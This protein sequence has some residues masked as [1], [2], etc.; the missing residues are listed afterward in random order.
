MSATVLAEY[1]SR[2][3]CAQEHNSSLNSTYQLS[4]EFPNLI[5]L[6][7]AGQPGLNH[8]S[9]P[10]LAEL[11]RAYLE[12]FGILTTLTIPLRVRGETIAYA[13]LRES[14]HQRDFTPE[15]IAL[16]QGI[17]QQA[18]VAIKHTQLYDETRRQAADL[19]ALYTVT[20]MASQ[21]LVLEEVL[22]QVLTSALTALGF[23]A[24][25]ISLVDPATGQ[26][27]LAAERGLPPI[28][29]TYFK[30]NELDSALCR[31]VYQR[32]EA[33]LISDL[34][35]GSPLDVSEMVV[36]GFWAYAGVPLFHNGQ[37]LGTF[38]LFS[39]HKH[40]SSP[41]ELALLTASG[42]QVATAVANARLFEAIADERSRL[43][44]LIEASRDGVTLIGLDQRILVTNA[45]TLAAL[46]LSGTPEDWI[47]QRV[48]E[49]LGS[50]RRHAP[51]VVHLA[52]AE[53]RRL[54]QGDEQP[55]EGEVEV[56]GRVLHWLNSPVLA[57]HIPIGRLV[58]LRDVTQERQLDKMRDDLVHT[59]V[60]DL[61]NPLTAI[62]GSLQLLE[63][64]TPDLSPKQERMLSIARNRTSE[65]LELVNSILKVSQLESGRLPLRYTSF[66]LADLIEEAMEAQGPLTA[67]KELQLESDVSP[68]LPP[69]WADSNLVERV[70]QNLIGNAIKFTPAGGQIRITARLD[71]ETAHP[72]REP[73]HLRVSVADTGPGI[74]LELQSRLFQKFVSGHQ[75]G[76]GSGLGLAFCKLAIE[77][78]GG[79][80][81]VDS[82]PGQGATFTFT[83]PLVRE[84]SVVKRVN[85][86]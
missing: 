41:E 50:L 36:S 34:S 67:D 61:R 83:L 57:G 9:D 11:H 38:S 59:M 10:D 32:R 35:I 18:A 15:E 58:V 48:I 64:I 76:S 55:Q 71:K 16:C 37:V 43:Q 19:N 75:E 65:M 12:R 70:L 42:R 23:E 54:K 82:Q 20:R 26:L 14:R 28:L 46:G 3:A 6:L 27:T 72:K 49:V 22:N 79:R 81:W 74:P 31:H 51:A 69:L 1:I 78:H 4:Q 5:D 84:G 85:K 25:I 77:A 44:A 56:A 45:P 40:R 8:K 33:L 13:E 52:M 53:L 24:G 17:A 66:S 73:A 39:R 68:L 80:I 29:A 62:D 60:H 47:G 63:M 2:Q 21:S 7:A 30:Y 86:F